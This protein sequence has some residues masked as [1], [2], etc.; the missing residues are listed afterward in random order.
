MSVFRAYDVRGIVGDDLTIELV[1]KIGKA[2]GTEAAQ[3]G[4]KQVVI[5]RDGRLSGEQLQNA[6]AQGIISTGR[7]VINVGR[8]PTPVLYFTTYHLQTG[9]GVMV[10]GSH[11]PPEYNGLK[12]MLD[13]E[14]LSGGSIQS[15]RERVENGDFIQQAQGSISQFAIEDIYIQ[16]IVNDVTL[17]RPFKVVVDS[18]NGVAG[19]IAPKLLRALGCEVIELFC[20]IDGNFP[21]HHPDPSLPE[22]LQDLIKAVKTHQA[23]IGLAFD[24]DADRL[25]VVDVNGQIVFPDRQMMLYAMDVLKRNQGAKIIYDV[26]CSRHL[27]RVIREHGGEPVMWKTGHSLI[28]SK[29]KETGSPL[30]GEMSGHIFFKERWYGFDDAIY[31]A[32]RLLEI[33]ASDPRTPT[34]V[35]SA[36]PNAVSTPELKLELAHYGEHFQLMEKVSSTFQFEGAEV[37]TIDGVRADF[38]DGWGLVRSSNTTP[39]LVIRFEADTQE[40]LEKIQ[41]DFRRQFMAIDSG[42][43]LPF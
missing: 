38:K 41:A 18:G 3:K 4:I 13:G 14:T 20:E 31:T 5:A 19:E 34:E 11:N 9:T 6:L 21:N 24:G 16:R 32:A 33:L 43:K 15:L 35:L 29:L 28:K 8:V 40:A 39:C 26:K 1:E 42:L 10:T 7:D 36:L 17:K 12:I 30:A 23:D 22:N 27:S 37:S 25:G 2:I